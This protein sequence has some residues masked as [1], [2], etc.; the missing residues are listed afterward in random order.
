[1]QSSC[2]DLRS[3][4]KEKG[5]TVSTTKSDYACTRPDICGFDIRKVHAIL[6]FKN[7]Y[8]SNKKS[9]RCKVDGFTHLYALILRPDLTYEVK[10]DGQ[11]IESGGIEYDWNLTSLKKMEK[12]SAES[13]DWEQVED[14]KSQVWIFPPKF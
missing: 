11:S 1:V 13:K 6:H 14:S 2:S 7:Q 5:V 8:H 9:I 10:I 3:N 4:L 12:T